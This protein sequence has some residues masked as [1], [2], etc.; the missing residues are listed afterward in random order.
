MTQELANYK[1]MLD[2]VLAKIH[3]PSIEGLLKDNSTIYDDLEST[4]YHEREEYDKFITNTT[5]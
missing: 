4:F 5:Q 2:Y 3:V 1:M